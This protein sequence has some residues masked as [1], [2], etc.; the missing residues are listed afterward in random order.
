ME[1]SLILRLW[2][3][4]PFRARQ[5]G[6]LAVATIGQNPD[7]CVIDRQYPHV[8]LARL[9]HRILPSEG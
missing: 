7:G 1:I 5:V 9:A 3:T 4:P 2:K 8:G 6:F